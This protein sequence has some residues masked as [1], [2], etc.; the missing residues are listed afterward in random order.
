LCEHATKK[1]YVSNVFN[2]LKSISKS[3]YQNILHKKMEMILT[4]I[5]KLAYIFEKIDDKSILD[6]K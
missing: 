3:I 6:I 2:C 4:S 5:T 1:I